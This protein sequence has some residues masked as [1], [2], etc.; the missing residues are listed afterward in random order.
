MPQELDWY[1]K[2]WDGTKAKRKEQTKET[3]LLSDWDLPKP[4]PDIDQK[5]DIDGM[6]LGKLHIG[7]N[8]PKEK[9]IDVTA[10]LIPLPTIEEEKALEE[11]TE[12]TAELTK[13][14]KRNQQ[15]EEKYMM[16]QRAY[17][18]QL[19]EEEESDTQTTWKMIILSEYK[20]FYEL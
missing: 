10:S 11:M 5:T 12:K 15:I 14:G 8:D 1:S 20:N 6:D 7:Q 4:Q 16:Y 18:E 2:D 19:S 3:N 13:V 9:Q 17:I